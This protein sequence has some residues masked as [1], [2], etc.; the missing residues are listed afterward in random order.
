MLHPSILSVKQG[1]GR[2][3]VYLREGEDSQEMKMHLVKGVVETESSE[4]FLL[5]DE[6]GD[7]PFPL[8]NEYSVVEMGSV[9]SC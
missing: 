7:E 4:S 3:R 5:A 1:V 6:D 9:S 2:S 8:A